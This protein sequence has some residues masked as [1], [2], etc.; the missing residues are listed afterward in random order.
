MNANIFNRRIQKLQEIMAEK[1]IDIGLV[2]DRENLIYFGDIEQVE[3]MVIII[4]QE[5]KPVGITLWLDM[6]YARDNCCLEDVRAYVFPRQSLAGSIIEVIQEM[7][8][9]D[10]VIGFERYFVSFGVFDQLRNAFD[11]AKFVSLA[12]DIYKL[13]AVKTAE[14]IELIKKASRAVCAGMEAAVRVLKPGL[15]ELDIAAEAEYAAMK[16]GSQGTPFR[17]QVVSGLRTLTT[18][19]FAT[20]KVIENG[21]IMLIHIGAKCG[22]YIAKMC[23]TA[24]IGDVPEEQKNIYQIIKQSQIEAIGKLRPGVP[25]RDVCFAA[26]EV[27]EKAGYS[28]HFLSVIGYGVGL[29]QSE[30][31]PVIAV[32]SD[33]VLE[34]NMVVDVLLPSIYK[35]GVG[36]ARITDTILITASEPEI[37]TDYSNDLIIV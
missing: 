18:H 31:Y 1:G 11:A 26:G 17:P 12:E 16:A 15:K 37:L 33:A 2:F 27:V 9:H 13:R 35:K 19:P 34:E 4:P 7:G 28:K 14:E 3:C 29:R 32:N 8:Y 10:P 25:V 21:E 23:R 22:G 6:E 24:V 20:E 30:F 5:G 36:G